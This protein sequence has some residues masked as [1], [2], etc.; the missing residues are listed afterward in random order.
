MEIGHGGVGAHGTRI[1]QPAVE[2]CFAFVFRRVIEVGGFER[3]A[4]ADDVTAAAA[5][6][7]HQRRAHLRGDFHPLGQVEIPARAQQ[8]DEQQ[9]GKEK[10][11]V[12]Q[13][14]AGHRG[15]GD[16]RLGVER[17]GAIHE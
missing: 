17:E 5:V 3:A 7:F 11:E 10:E 13:G 9:Q 12:R 4:P 2:R 14:F 15:I 1:R 8:R 16:W 6:F